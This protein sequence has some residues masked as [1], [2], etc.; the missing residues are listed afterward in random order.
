MNLYYYGGGFDLAA[1]ALGKI[2][3]VD[4]F[5]LR[6]L[7][8]RWWDWAACSWSGRL[9]PAA[10]RPGL[11]PRRP[12]PAAGLPPVL[13]PHVFMNAKDAPFAVA[14]AMLIYSMVR[15]LDEYPRPSWRTVAF[16]GVSLGLAEGTRVLGVITVAYAGLALAL[17]AALEWRTARL[18]D[19]GGSPRPVPRP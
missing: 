10:R 17:L 11:R 19:H 2:L 18:Q 6:R 5:D 12:K 16:F 8:A 4:V 1:A 15:A 13:R 7:L 9:G 14:V 3:P